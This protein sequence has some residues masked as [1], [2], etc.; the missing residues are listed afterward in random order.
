MSQ[1]STTSGSGNKSG[2]AQSPTTTL[3]R[4]HRANSD[5]RSRSKSRPPSRP[6]NT[7]MHQGAR[8]SSSCTSSSLPSLSHLKAPVQL[9]RATINHSPGMKALNELLLPENYPIQLW[10][11]HLMSFPE[12]SHV[13]T[14]HERVV[15]YVLCYVEGHASVVSKPPFP[16]SSSSTALGDSDAKFPDS[17]TNNSSTTPGIIKANNSNN[18]S[19]S[20]SSNSA[21]D[22]SCGIGHVTSLAVHPEF[23]NL[24]IAT[25][26]MDLALLEMA[27]AYNC[28]M[29]K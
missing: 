3:S 19:S 16:A 25:M 7:T 11:W 1:K 4:H 12:L 2:T 20:G 18:C 23:Q 24:G 21:S 14:H 8:S 17:R 6:R 22:G 29:C 9:Q 13:V 10:V 26:L 5:V 27:R 28:S 15:G